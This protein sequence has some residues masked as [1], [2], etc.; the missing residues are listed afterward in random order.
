MIC[1]IGGVSAE[2]YK[3]NDNSD[4]KFR[5]TLNNAIPSPSTTFNIT[6]VYP[7]GTTQFNNVQT[8]SIGQGLFNYTINFT[9]LGNYKVHQFCYDG[10]YNYS[11]TEEYLVTGNGNPEPSGAVIVLFSI[12][13]IILFGFMTYVIIYS[14]GHSISLDFDIIDVAYNWGL[15]FAVVVVQ[16]LQ[17]QYLGNLAIDSLL[18]WMIY[19]GIF[20]MVFL[21]LV[22]FILT[23]TI[24]TWMSRRVKGVDM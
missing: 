18:D 10:A 3:I 6:I 17:K 21:P 24:G 11:S 14:I 12:I 15:F 13:L 4:L 16:L 5:C 1:L 22:Y 7:N 8:T 20:V 19:I 2:T 9:T 23:L